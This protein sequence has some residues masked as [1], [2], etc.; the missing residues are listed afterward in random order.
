MIVKKLSKFSA[1]EILT[2]INWLIDEVRSL[3]PRRGAGTT[4]SKTSK[5]TTHKAKA[6]QSTTNVTGGTTSVV[7]RWG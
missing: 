5:G 7:A 4:V 2:T 1:R 6:S 3:K